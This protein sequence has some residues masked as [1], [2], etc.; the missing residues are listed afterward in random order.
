MAH[1]CPI[2]LQAGSHFRAGAKLTRQ[3][4]GGVGGDAA[5][6]EHDP[7]FTLYLKATAAQSARDAKRGENA[8][9]RRNSALKRGDDEA[10][11]QEYFENCRRTPVHHDG[12][13]LTEPEMQIWTPTNDSAPSRRRESPATEVPGCQW[14]ALNPW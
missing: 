8:Q 6:L 14:D 1:S 12:R 7:P 9:Q 13:T 10:E 5:L 3:T 4:Q 2:G 11:V